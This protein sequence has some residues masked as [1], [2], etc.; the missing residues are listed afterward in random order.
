MINFG[1]SA[2]LGY[3]F[4][5]LNIGKTREVPLI[6]GDAKTRGLKMLLAVSQ[7]GGDILQIFFLL[8]ERYYEFPSCY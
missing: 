7:K 5:T 6:P 2:L 4:G 8:S 3:R 1:A